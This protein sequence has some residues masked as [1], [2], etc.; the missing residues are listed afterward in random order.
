LDKI[1]EL[2]AEADRLA[3]ENYLSADE[4]AALNL[5][6][7]SQF[8]N[9]VLGKKIG[10][11]ASSVRRELPF[12]ARCSPGELAEITGGKIESGLENEFVVVQGVADLV[13]LL[14]AEI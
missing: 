2:P 5:T 8:W 11:P 7:L 3:R 4:R 14:P 6:A 10:A 1:N 12:T 13:V 9:S